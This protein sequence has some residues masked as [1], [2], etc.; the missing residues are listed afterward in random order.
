MRHLL[1]RRSAAS[2]VKR[3]VGSSCVAAVIVIAGARSASAQ[4]GTFLGGQ[5]TQGQTA[6]TTTAPVQT[7]RQVYTDPTMQSAQEGLALNLTAFEMYQ[8]NNLGLFQQPTP[9]T[10]PVYNRSGARTGGTAALTYRKTVQGT[11]GAFGT[12]SRASANIYSGRAA[13]PIYNVRSDLFGSKPLGRRTTV[14]AS[15]SV[16]YAPYYTFGLIPGAAPGLGLSNTLLDPDIDLAAGR[17]QTFRYGGQ[18]GLQRQV[19]LHSAFSMEYTGRHS[20][21]SGARPS[22]TDQSGSAHYQYQLRRDLG[23]T[24]GYLY[25]RA[26]YAIAGSRDFHNIDAGVNYNKGISFGG[27]T[28]TLSFSTGSSIVGR[29]Y[30]VTRNAN[31]TYRLQLTGRANL[32]R[33]LGRTWSAHVGYAR[34][35]DFVDAF[36]TPLFS[37]RVVMGVG[38]SLGQ[39]AT[40]GTSASYLHGVVDQALQTYTHTGWSARSSLQYT[41]WRNLSAY[42]NYAY[43]RYDFPSAVNLPN[44]VPSALERS[45]VRGGLSWWIPLGG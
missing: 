21:F 39:R 34:G 15:G 8:T 44:G 4:N 11:R 17:Q 27:R 19:S 37:D 24:V 29:E 18:I 13:R 6:T 41:L 5:V 20:E 14:A 30:D 33:N 38:G 2:G 3:R 10:T 40:F 32:T 9:G 36:D 26:R 31:Q 16:T 25:R 35:W 12:D 43:Y 22:F 42:A 23:L 1:A 45:G 7:P 28:M